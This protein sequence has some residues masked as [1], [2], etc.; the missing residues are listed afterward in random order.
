[1]QQ[2]PRT[3]P[4]VSCTIVLLALYAPLETW[5]SLPALWDPFY[6]V[7][8]IGMAL[9]AWGVILCRRPPARGVEAVLVA[10]YAWTGANGWRAAFGRVPALASGELAVFSLEMGF[11]ACGTLLVLGGLVWAL[12]LAIREA[13]G[14]AGALVS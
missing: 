10:G 7:D 8:V 2:N 5:F 9:L 13:G 4:L 3:K 11:V 12:R 1:M 14:S 6:L